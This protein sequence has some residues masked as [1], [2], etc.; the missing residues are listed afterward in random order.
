MAAINFGCIS[1]LHPSTFRSAQVSLQSGMFQPVV[2][3][4]INLPGNQVT[5][6]RPTLCL[7]SHVLGNGLKWTYPGRRDKVLFFNHGFL[8]ERRDPVRFWLLSA[9][10]LS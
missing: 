3:D 6:I 2:D 4:Y 1:S 5:R 7:C 9:S 10:M 8:T